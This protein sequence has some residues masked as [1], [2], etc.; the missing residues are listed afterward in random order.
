MAEWKCC[1]SRVLFSDKRFT[2]EKFI[3]PTSSRYIVYADWVKSL[4]FHKP[5]VVFEQ[6]N[7]SYISDHDSCNV[8]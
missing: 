5:Y 3:R 2:G 1:L 8:R 7:D 4:S 6:G